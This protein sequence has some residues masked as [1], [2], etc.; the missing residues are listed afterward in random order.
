M[1]KDIIKYD[2]E[3]GIRSILV[4]AGQL[5]P[6]GKQH[7]LLISDYQWSADGKKLLIFTNSVREWRYETKGDY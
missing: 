3:S 5:I 6:N 4:S 1:A 7:P 2:P